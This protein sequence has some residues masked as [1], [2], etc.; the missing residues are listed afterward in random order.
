MSSFRVLLLSENNFVDFEKV[1]ERTEF[2]SDLIRNDEI[3]QDSL[4]ERLGCVD[5]KTQIIFEHCYDG[6][7]E[8]MVWKLLRN[9]NQKYLKIYKNQV[10]FFYFIISL[11]FI[12]KFISNSS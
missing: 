2:N 4:L 8:K 12:I 6:N 1:F 10:I 5:M 7:K 9:G 3:H 11:K